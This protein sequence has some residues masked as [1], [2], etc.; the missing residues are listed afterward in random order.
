MGNEANEC[1]DFNHE[2]YKLSFK[3]VKSEVT[4]FPEI[5][6]SLAISS[7]VY[8]NY[9]DRDKG[10]G[11]AAHEHR[12]RFCRWVGIKYLLCS[13]RRDNAAQH[14]IMEKFK[15]NRL[16]ETDTY[17]H[18]IVMYGRDLSDIPYEK[19]ERVIE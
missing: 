1:P 18:N 12:L 17:C 16:D 15:W 5:N 3:G 10:L 8:V 11:T 7:K 9:A 4:Y 2:G 6:Y 14:K 19:T 13:V